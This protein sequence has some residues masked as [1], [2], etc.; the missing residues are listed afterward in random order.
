MST[1]FEILINKNLYNINEIENF[2]GRIVKDR[3]CLKL[4]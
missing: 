1:D 2:H 4:K 3:Y